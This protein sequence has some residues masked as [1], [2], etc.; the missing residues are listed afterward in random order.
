MP[1][2]VVGL[3]AIKPS[4]RSE[5]DTDSAD[6]NAAGYVVACYGNG[7]PCLDQPHHSGVFLCVLD[8]IGLND[9]DLGRSSA[10]WEIPARD[11][12]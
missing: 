1:P 6:A 3:E 10:R 9:D 7:M 5:N 4:L 12:T 11:V 2:A 8:L